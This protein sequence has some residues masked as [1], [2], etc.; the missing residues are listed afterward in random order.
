MELSRRVFLSSLAL[1]AH[2]TATAKALPWS[3]QDSNPYSDPVAADEWIAKALAKLG[4]STGPLQLGRFADPVYFLLKEIEWAPEPGQKVASVR[5]PI[6]F[7]TDFASIPRAFWSLL[8]P[9]ALYTF[10]AIV[11]DYLYWE[12][13]GTRSEADLTLKYAMEEFQVGKATVQTVYAGVRVGGEAAWAA[14]ASLRRAGEK[15][16]LKQFPTDPRVRWP[17]WKTGDVFK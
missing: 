14:N 13:R 7:V 2:G 17:I 3:V 6:G 4:A 10:P 15:R 1:L 5:V 12:Q 11:H 9:D 8:P 16:V